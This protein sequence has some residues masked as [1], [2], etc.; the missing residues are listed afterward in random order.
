MDNLRHKLQF[1]IKS[2]PTLW[3]TKLKLRIL[4][5]LKRSYTYYPTQFET[6]RIG[7]KLKNIGDHI[8]PGGKINNVNLRSIHNKEYS[9]YFNEAKI[10]V[11][12]PNNEII[13]WIDK[14]S[15]PL[16]GVMFL[17]GKIICDNIAQLIDG[18]QTDEVS[19]A[20][21][22]YS[23]S[24]TTAPN[25]FANQ[26]Y[27]KDENA[28][29]QKKTNFLILILTVITVIDGIVGLKTVWEGF[30]FTLKSIL[31]SIGHL[32]VNLGHL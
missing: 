3:T 22:L 23:Y 30:V 13:I 31:S 4:S 21:I 28:E 11:L 19:K 5:L 1:E 9:I 17:Q 29:K 8:F 2:E 12:D 6:F 26:F 25:S 27:I 20:P 32:L 7:L 14:V 16:N 24:N 18:Y 15:T 10:N